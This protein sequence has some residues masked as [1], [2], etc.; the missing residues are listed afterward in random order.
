MTIR[1]DGTRSLPA[2]ESVSAADFLPVSM[3]LS[4]LRTRRIADH[5]PL[6]RSIALRVHANLPRHIDLSDIIDAGM[7]GL[8]EAAS[9][10]DLAK[11][12]AFPSYAKHRIQGSILDK[13]RQKNH[14]PRPLTAVSTQVAAAVSKTPVRDEIAADL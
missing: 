3:Q 12:V 7:R 6:V 4:V 13:L 1:I 5:L 8:S 9:R 11:E 14:A 10:F 2:F